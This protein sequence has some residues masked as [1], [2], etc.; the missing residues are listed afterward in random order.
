MDLLHIADSSAGPAKVAYTARR[1]FENGYGTTRR[2]GVST[3]RRAPEY[4]D[5]VLCE[6]TRLG[7]HKAVAQ[8]DGVRNQLF[9][10]EQVV[11]AYGARY[12]PDQFEAELPADMGPCDLVAAGGV[13]ARVVSQHAKMSPATT[14]RPI[15]LLTDDESGHVIDTRALAMRSPLAGTDAALGTASPAGT[16]AAAPVIVAVLGTSMNAGKTTAAACLARGL[17]QAGRRV[18][19]AKVT[20]TGAP[21][22]PMLMKAA[23]AVPVLDFTDLGYPAT[24]KLP[25]PTIES[26]LRDTVAHLAAARVDVAVLEI[27]D[28][29]LQPE[30]AALIDSPAFRHLVDRV[31]F[32]AA[33]SV[34]ALAGTRDLLARGLPVAA[35]TGALTQSPLATGK[36]AR[37]LGGAVVSTSDLTLPDVALRV[38]DRTHSAWTPAAAPRV[39]PSTATVRHPLVLT[40]AAAA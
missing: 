33:D 20:G 1:L 21:G 12:A 5:L 9:V 13:A 28:G 32:A 11:V 25:Q 31:V 4:G 17:V 14:L 24:Y 19:A 38:L 36:A 18:G 3:E 15:G 40:G 37:A 34:S 39:E 7:Q 30:T 35:V 23:G 16:P 29:I 22:D 10:G 6:V 27:A 8:R 2:V 26:L